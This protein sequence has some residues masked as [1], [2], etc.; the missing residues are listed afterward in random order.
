MQSTHCLMLL[1]STFSGISIPSNN[2]TASTPSNTTLFSPSLFSIL[3]CVV[4]ITIKSVFLQHCSFVSPFSSPS[5]H[6]LQRLFLHNISTP[7]TSALSVFSINSCT[8][9]SSSSITNLSVTSSPTVS[10][11]LIHCVGTTTLFCFSCSFTIAFGVPS[12]S[13]SS[14]VTSFPISHSSIVTFVVVS[15]MST[16]VSFCVCVSL[17]L[18]LLLLLFLFFA[19]LFFLLFLFWPACVTSAFA[20]CLSS[21]PAPETGGG[22]AAITGPVFHAISVRNSSIT[23][24]IDM[25]SLLFFS[26]DNLPTRR[27]VSSSTYFLRASQSFISDI[28]L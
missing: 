13:S 5:V 19:L 26:S 7:F 27:T 11:L 28:C 10:L 24:F 9:A 3:Q 12:V 17:L 14:T 8:H 16:T 23:S 18:L 21:S 6:F 15:C 2:C 4:L 22:S 25:I 20:P 1:I